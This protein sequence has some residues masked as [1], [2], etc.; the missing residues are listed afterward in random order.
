[1]RAP[2]RATVFGWNF[3]KPT[4]CREETSG[5]LS[6]ASTPT[7]IGRTSRCA[8]CLAK[9]YSWSKELLANGQ[10]G[11]QFPTV[12]WFAEVKL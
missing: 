5:R 7:G 11:G 1:M 4:S 9:N 2:F 3:P 10:H 6:V 8:N 12:T